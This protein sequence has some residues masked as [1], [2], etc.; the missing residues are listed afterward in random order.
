[1]ALKKERIHLI[2]ELRGVAIIFVVFYHLFYNLETVGGIDLGFFNTPWFGTVRY[3][4]TALL[5]LLSGISCNFSR[6]NLKR[7]AVCFLIGCG[8]TAVTYFFLP[9][10]LI[11]FGVLHMFG[12]CMLLYGL[13]RPLLDKISPVIG[14]L[15]GLFLFITMWNVPTGYITLFGFRI[16]LPYQLYSTFYLF[17]L[18]FPGTGFYSADYYPLIPWFFMFLTGGFL[19]V[20]IK[21]KRLPPYMDF[22][23]DGRIHSRFLAFTGRHTL[24]IY[25]IHQ[26]LLFGAV[27]LLAN[28]L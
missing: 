8:I 24:L 16:D 13:L 18:G 7:G 26:P 1:M 14:I 25:L 3:V 22:L 17:P 28:I 6:S 21:E 2:D 20:F 9:Q 27:Y 23:Y 5:V 11:L 4:N 19:G 12:L 15:A 10:F